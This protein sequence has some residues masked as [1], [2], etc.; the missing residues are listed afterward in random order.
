MIENKW[1]CEPND[2]RECWSFLILRLDNQDRNFEIIGWDI[3]YANPRKLIRKLKNKKNGEKE[4]VNELLHEIYYCRKNNITLITFR[5]DIIPIIRTRILLLN[6]NDASLRGIKYFSMEKLLKKYFLFYMSNTSTTRPSV[7][8]NKMNVSNEK[9]S[10]V[11]ML[12]KIF[13][14]IGPLLPDG[15]I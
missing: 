1:F 10:D 15:V 8:I 9:L 12:W 6:L 13:L 7:I 4:I 5:E 11:E 3:V 14:K 2:Q